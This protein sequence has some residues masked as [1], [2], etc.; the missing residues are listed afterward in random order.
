MKSVKIPKE[1]KI[2]TRCVSDKIIPDVKFDENG[3]FNFGKLHE[4]LE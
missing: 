4:K 3:D 2:S 1:Y